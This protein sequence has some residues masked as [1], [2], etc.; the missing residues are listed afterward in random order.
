MLNSIAKK[1]AVLLLFLLACNINANEQAT[2]TVKLPL[3]AAFISYVSYASQNVPADYSKTMAVGRSHS[4]TLDLGDVILVD[5]L[6]TLSEHTCHYFQ[7]VNGGEV[8]LKYTGASM[9]PVYNLDNVNVL[10]LVHQSMTSFFK[11]C[12]RPD[13]IRDELYKN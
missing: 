13:L 5:T 8:T 6:S 4:Q 11:A 1:S 3:G 9:Y 2:V 10:N 12:D 7:V